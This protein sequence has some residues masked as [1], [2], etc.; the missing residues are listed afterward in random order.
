MNIGII[1]YGSLGRALYN[2]LGKGKIHSIHICEKKRIKEK[3]IRTAD[4]ST[5]I[6]SDQLFISVNDD[7]IQN[8]VM[9]LRSFKNNIVFFSASVEMSYLKKHLKHAKSISIFHPIQSFSKNTVKVT[10]FKSIYAT[11]EERGKNEFLHQFAVKNKIKVIKVNKKINR[12]LYHL[13]SMLAGNYTLTLILIAS[14]LIKESLNRK[15]IGYEVFLPM[16]NSLIKRI[17][18]ENPKNVISGPSARDDKKKIQSMKRLLKEK[19]LAILLS[20]L[21]KRTKRAL[22]NG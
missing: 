20:I 4:I 11:L 7:S 12:N 14:D 2:S 19:D 3:G 13:S 9:K 6:K 10:Q 22:Q 18:K 17:N 16:L 15:G 21:D 8:I 1:G 5:I